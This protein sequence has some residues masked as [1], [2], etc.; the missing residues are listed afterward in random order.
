MTRPLE[1]YGIDSLEAIFGREFATED[2]LLDLKEE[3]EIRTT[4]RAKG[5]LDK[6]AKRLALLQKLKAT[7]NSPVISPPAPKAYERVPVEI[8]VLL[9][10]PSP[11]K[12]E[13]VK[14]SV[15]QTAFASKNPVKPTS[16]EFVVVMTQEQALRTLKV[17]GTA[18]WEQIEQ[19][20]RELVARAQPDRLV[21]LSAEKRTALQDECKQV[22][23]AY[24]ALLQFKI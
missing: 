16:A 13:S 23:A 18:S 22:N 14:D 9:A 5:L 12:V 4:Q 21:G 10:G 8:P 24:K 1:R 7:S 11:A 19:S 20:R 17:S 3:L 15:E 6:V 2:E